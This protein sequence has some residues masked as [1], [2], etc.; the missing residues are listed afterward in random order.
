MRTKFSTSELPHIWAAQCQP[1]GKSDNMFFYNK[2]IYSYGYHYC[3]GN[4]LDNGI[5]LLNNTRYSNTTAKH[6]SKI[7]YA[8]NHKKTIYVKEPNVLP[9]G[10]KTSYNKITGSHKNNI[11]DFLSQI[12]TLCVKHIRAQK[13]SYVNQIEKLK[14][15]IVSYCEIMNIRLLKS[16]LSIINAEIEDIGKITVKNIRVRK[17]NDFREQLKKLKEW[18]GD[19]RLKTNN[20]NTYIRV[21]GDKVET[22]MGASVPINEAKTLLH[23]IQNNK[24]IHGFKIGFYTVI[25]INGTLKIGCHE[26][27]REEIERFTTFYKW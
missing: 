3:A 18:T 23:M 5:V 17:E 13:Y 21:K 22:N 11:D 27:T 7:Y 6:M 19:N 9:L 15:D 2:K 8:V 26:I 1:E 16:Q 12:E 4:I 24:P 14:S 10:E 20:T 25:G